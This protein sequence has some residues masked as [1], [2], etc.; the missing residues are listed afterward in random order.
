MALTSFYAGA[1]LVGVLFPLWIMMACDSNPRLV[2]QRGEE[3]RG[4]GTWVG[5]VLRHA[6]LMCLPSA[7]PTLSR[8]VAWPAMWVQG[9]C[10]RCWCFALRSMFLSATAP[11]AQHSLLAVLGEGGAAA[12]AT[13]P[14]ASLPP[15]PVFRSACWVT[16]KLL[17]NASLIPRLVRLFGV[18]RGRPPRPATSTLSDTSSLDTRQ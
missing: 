4:R 14:R 8:L 2:Y 7:T 5:R 17:G 1:A 9:V 10:A 11:P 6:G 18:P 12:G 16:N 13:M 3:G 15:L